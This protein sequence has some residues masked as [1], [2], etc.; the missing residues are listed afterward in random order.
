VEHISENSEMKTNKNH[1]TI[2]SNV[3]SEEVER[4]SST[5]YDLYHG[6]SFREP[7]SR[8]V[9]LL[10]G[11][12]KSGKGAMTKLAIKH[13]RASAIGSEGL[14]VR[15]GKEKI[16]VKPVKKRQKY[17]I[18]QDILQSDYRMQYIRKDGKEEDI[19]ELELGDFNKL[20]DPEV[21][22]M[23]IPHE[24]PIDVLLIHSPDENSDI[25][26]ISKVKNA[27]QF[28]E[29]IKK[30]KTNIRK[31]S[32]QNKIGGNFMDFQYRGII[33][34]R[35]DELAEI[36][37]EFNERGVRIMKLH[38]PNLDQKRSEKFMAKAFRLLRQN[39]KEA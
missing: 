28:I 33:D 1:Y 19:P 25:V 14:S 8:K 23:G 7:F 18:V 37:N 24:V 15:L 11:K 10:L 4:E 6:Q 35:E 34:L 38:I 30:S 31:I 36:F 17:D 5:F 13:K 26:D 16:Y 20:L 9:I 22:K 32:D 29:T 12:S 3:V 27:R 21:W 2:I 39:L